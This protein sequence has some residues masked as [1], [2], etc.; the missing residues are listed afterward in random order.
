MNIAEMGMFRWIRSGLTKYVKMREN[1]LKWLSAR[2]CFKAVR[3]V[4]G[5]MCVE[6]KRGIEI[7][8]NKWSDVIK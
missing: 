8:K 5:G 6:G 2:A 7:L 4:K 1:R 3:L